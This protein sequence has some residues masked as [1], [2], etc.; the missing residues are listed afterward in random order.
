MRSTSRWNTP[1]KTFSFTPPFSFSTP[2]TPTTSNKCELQCKCKI[3]TPLKSRGPHFVWMRPRSTRWIIEKWSCI[4]LMGH[5]R[6]YIKSNNYFCCSSTVHGSWLSAM[7]VLAILSIIKIVEN[8][9]DIK[10]TTIEIHRDCKTIIDRVNAPNL[11]QCHIPSL[12]M[13]SY[14][15]KLNI[16]SDHHPTKYNYNIS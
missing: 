1:K 4:I 15:Y 13:L 16:C 9:S 3:H 2:T 8:V 7:P 10:D 5:S 11:P 12:T 14:S 6:P